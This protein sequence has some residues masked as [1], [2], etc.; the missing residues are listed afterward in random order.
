MKK[1]LRQKIHKA[2]ATPE[3]IKILILRTVGN[4]LILISIF[5]ICRTFYKPA[6][7]EARYFF[8]RL[9]EKRYIVSDQ[10][11]SGT[12]AQEQQSTSQEQLEAAEPPSK[13]K[14]A[15]LLQ[16]KQ[17]EIL[18]PEDPE[19]SIV[20]PKVGAN[21]RV[22]ANVNPASQEEYSEALKNGVAH[23]GNTMLP[24]EGGHVFLFAH[25]TDYWWNVGTYNAVFYL[26]YKLENGDEVDIFYKR[27]RYTYK[28]IGSEIVKPDQVE[29]IT[30]KSNKEFL[31][32]QTCWP[33]GTTLERLVVFAVPM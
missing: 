25:S 6:R 12:S 33:P 21:S 11:T 8:D 9:I 28:V 3:F 20:I 26:L 27:H 17:I 23:A 4:F 18:N 22:I 16:L 32:L 24:G 31:T 13:N 7:E 1:T 30:R 29:Y 19:F 2:A 10:D 14:L 15:E 5:T